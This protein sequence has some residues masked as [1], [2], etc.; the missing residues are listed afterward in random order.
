LPAWAQAAAAVLVFAAGL[1]AGTLGDSPARDTVA[2]APAAPVASPPAQAQ[3]VSRP[4]EPAPAPP[5]V[6][7]ADLARL[8]R[9]LQAIESAQR[10]SAPAR[11]VSAASVGRSADE[12]ASL[13]RV[14][15]Q[16][17]ALRQDIAILADAV[18][19]M[20]AQYR[21]LE[22]RVNPQ[23]VTVEQLERNRES[24]GLLTTP[25]SFPGRFGR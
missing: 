21:Y 19:N 12:P 3:V 24:R 25:V 15:T 7:A 1:T 23:S 8:E 11:T 5:A 14:D 22:R 20:D 13:A 16:I 18:S 2:F 4:A 6:F 10:G 9:R 17:G